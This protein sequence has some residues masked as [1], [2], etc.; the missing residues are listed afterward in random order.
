MKLLRQSAI[1]LVICLLGEMINK[2]IEIPIPGNVIGMVLLLIFLSTGIIKLR[3]IDKVSDFLLDHLAFFF[4]PAG[5]QILTSFDI[6]RG[7]LFSILVI[8]FISTIV[9][10]VVTGFTV[11]I[12]KGGCSHEGN[13]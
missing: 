8:I 1:I 6:L 3:H 13:N 11:Q 10:L 9:V 4:V 7:S 5:V 2:I 12:L